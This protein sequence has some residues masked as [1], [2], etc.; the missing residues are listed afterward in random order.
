[1]ALD[2][3]ISIPIGPLRGM[4]QRHHPGASS[5]RILRDL[6][7]DE[8]DAWR[9]GGGYRAIIRIPGNV[10]NTWTDPYAGQGAVSSIAWF[11]KSNG[12]RQFLIYETADGEVRIFNGSKNTPWDVMEDAEG[13]QITGRQV[14]D[15]PW[16]GTTSQTFGGRIYLF[17]GYD[18]PIVYDGVKAERAGF[19]ALPAP[20]S[21]QPIGDQNY[22]RA[23][24]IDTSALGDQSLDGM[25]MGI[26][27]ESGS[28]LTLDVAVQYV[29]TFVNERGQ[30]SPPSA[31]SNTVYVTNN[32]FG[33]S[34]VHVGVPT[35]P[36]NTV[37]RRIYRTENLLDTTGEMIQLG[38]GS[39]FLRLLEIQDNV[40]DSFEDYYPE[41]LLSDEVPSAL[42]LFPTGVK[43]AAVFQNTLFV[44]GMVE[45][46]VRYSRPLYPEVFPP[47]NLFEIGEADNGPITGM[48]PTKGALIVFKQQGIFVIRGNPSEGFYQTTLTR[49]VGC[50]S[51]RTVKELPGLGLAFLSGDGVYLLE[52]ALEN[53]GNPTKPVPLSRPIPDLIARINRN[54]MIVACAEVNHRT[55]ELWLAVPTIGSSKNDM[56]LRY[57]WEVNSWGYSTGFPIACMVETHDSR[58]YLIFGSND[59]DH[60]GLHVYSEGW[61][62]KDGVEI[63]ALYESAHLDIAS[64]YKSVIPKHVM[65]NI[66]GYGDNNVMLDYTANR[67]IDSVRGLEDRDPDEALQQYENASFPVYGE[68]VWGEDRWSQHRPITVRFDVG[69]QSVGSVREFQVSVT[70][71]GRSGQ[72]IG[73]DVEAEAGEKRSA[74]PIGTSTARG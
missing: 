1:M 42:G 35:G 66:V 73:F 39:K 64:I 71:A 15:G 65:L 25:G 52:G 21:A 28:S 59:T 45:N 62:D 32:E 38:V 40:T 31:F 20:P 27:T 44:A 10:P 7:W 49:D 69:T 57:S 18:T 56:L 67:N 33:R 8:R 51:L 74:L 6:V 55:K 19:D 22:S 50:A 61:P 68:A 2:P 72:L 17:N 58:G 43:F 16:Q 23:Y 13:N 46:E 41:A 47:D 4:D 26:L 5:A 54:A 12:A 48:Y 60:P 34:G 70:W 24:R 53:S 36:K 29:M 63:S 11:A 30:E 3:L 9:V 37:A 14:V